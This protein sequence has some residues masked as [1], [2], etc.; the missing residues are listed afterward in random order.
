MSKKNIKQNHIVL[1]ITSFNQLYN[2]LSHFDKNKLILNKKIYFVQISDH[3]PEE[4]NT[5]LIQYL[6]KFTE[7]EVID[8]RR[9]LINK[10]TKFLK[11]LLYYH[12]IIKKIFKL[13]KLLEMPI[14]AISGRMQ[15]PIFLLMFFFKSSEMFL[16][17]DGLGE[18]VPYAKNEKKPLLFFVLNKFFKLNNERI[19]VLQLAE[20]RND[21]FRILNPKYLKKENYFNNRNIYKNFIKSNFGNNLVNN[22]NC[23]VIGTNPLSQNFDYL[24]KLYIKTLL[25]IKE[26]YSLTSKQ[27]LFFTHPRTKLSYQIELNKCLSNYA[28]IHPTSSIIVENYLSLN[29]IET[30]VGSIS[31]ALLYAKTIFNK[32]NVYFLDNLVP[33]DIQKKKNNKE[34][35]NSDIKTIKNVGI[36]NF[37]D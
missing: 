22:T 16:M 23:I 30:V 2:F 27:I 15:I 31:S 11:T 19:K 8:F 34:R 26:K 7:V 32:K 29:N 5:Q 37:F 17:E 14:L 13:R 33:L 6:E 3:I 35:Y 1:V 18:Y 36:K 21:Y 24:K 10:K 25:S 20:S 4:L 12:F 28:N 9:S